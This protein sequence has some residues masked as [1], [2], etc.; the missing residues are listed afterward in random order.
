MWSPKRIAVCTEGNAHAGRAEPREV[1]RL[2]A[3][4]FLNFG[5]LFNW[6][7]RAFID[8]KWRITALFKDWVQTIFLDLD[9]LKGKQILANASYSDR[10]FREDVTWP[11]M[12]I[13]ARRAVSASRWSIM[14]SL[15]R[16]ETSSSPMTPKV[17]D[18]SFL[19]PS[20]IPSRAFARDMTRGEIDWR[21]S[22]IREPLKPLKG[23]ILYCFNSSWLSR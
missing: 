5:A 3:E 4:S 20:L 1:A 9:R 21:E 19:D 8:W 10:S 11:M 16:V 23:L 7:L 22:M 6:V 14:I 18:L 13:E 2:N 12:A 15:G 17:I